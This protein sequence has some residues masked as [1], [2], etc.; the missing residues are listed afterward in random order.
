MKEVESGARKIVK[1]LVKAGH[2]AYYVGGYVRDRLLGKETGDIDIAT[3]ALPE[4]IKTIFPQTYAVGESFG[5]VVVKTESI[6]YQVATFR[7]ETQYSDGRHPDKVKFS[8]MEADV[9][10][11]DFT[12]NGLY[13]DPLEDEVI[14]L[15]GGKQDL[16]KG[17]LRTIGEPEKR[18]EEDKLR[19][20]RA[21]RFASDLNFKIEKKTYSALKKLSHRV[22]EVSAERIREELMK[23]LESP[24]RAKALDLMY[25][26]VL[27]YILPEVYAL[28]GV[29]QPPEFHPEGDVYNHTR[30]MLEEMK[31]DD[32]LMAMAVLCHDIGKPPTFQVKERIRFDRH[33]RVGEDMTEEIC[34]RLKFPNRKRKL[35]KSLVRDHLKFINAKEMRESTLKRFLRQEHFDMHLEL[36]R[37]D[38]LASHGDLSIYEF[39][40]EKMEEFDK[41]EIEPPRLIDGNDLK[42]MGLEPG[43]VFGEILQRIETLQLDGK[44]ETHEEAISVVEDEYGNLL[45]N[46][47]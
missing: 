9:R 2:N 39:C 30:L 37:L 44:I 5:V 19:L 13:Y 45:N 32:P 23:T 14:D 4:E 16:E 21:I 12:I 40:G 15:V 29:H 31:E 34:R 47:Q 36:H 35:L 3:D 38:C 6:E 28:K 25:E 42:E 10:R 22:H 20:M 18:F 27:K 26:T 43:P 17:I 24:E 41:E 7:E 1:E 46:S 8:D 33:T 11:R